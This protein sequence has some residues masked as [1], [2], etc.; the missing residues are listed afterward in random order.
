LPAD[1]VYTADIAD[2]ATTGD[3]TGYLTTA[4][5]ANFYTTANESGFI[6]GVD[7]T[8]YQTT[9]G[10]TAY[11]PAGDYL[12][13]ADSAQ[14]IT[15]LPTDLVYTAD[16]QDMATTG[17]LTAYA[18]NS[19]LANK[20]DTSAFSSVSG[21]YLVGS[22]VS[23]FVIT[24]TGDGFYNGMTVVVSQDTPF[25]G[26]Y[27]S[28]SDINGTKQIYIDPE[29]IMFYSG[30]EFST[31]EAIDAGDIATLKTLSSSK[32]DNLTFSYTTANEISAINSSAIAGS[33]GSSFPSSANDA[34]E[35]VTANSANW[36]STYNTVT[37]NSADWSVSEEISGT[38]GI[39]ISENADKVI[40][41]VSADY[42][43][44]SNPSGFITGINYNTGSI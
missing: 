17:D 41:E 39:K 26:M 34:C 4:D 29:G 38:N 5:S 33:T 43:L 37:A 31:S 32:Q 9:A 16:I 11:Q 25:A 15:A 14:F 28:E 13:T 2:M 24:A 12:T 35:V 3:L 36:N 10:M 30:G 22:N 21:D 1:L 18:Q 44:A 8:P 40:I 27:L 7:L 42:Y 23:G 19:A 6:T 20:L